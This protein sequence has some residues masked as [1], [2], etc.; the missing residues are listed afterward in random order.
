MKALTF[1]YSDTEAYETL[2]TG[3]MLSD[4]TYRGA[5]VRLFTRTA[6]KLESIGKLKNDQGLF[7]LDWSDIKTGDTAPEKSIYFEDAEYNLLTTAFDKVE[8]KGLGCKTASQV[9]DIFERK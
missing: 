4:A 5:Q 6:E 9:Y 2:Y 1:Y 3:L 7:T 8:W